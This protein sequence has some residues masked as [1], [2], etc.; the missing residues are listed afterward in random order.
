MILCSHCTSLNCLSMVWVSPLILTYYTSCNITTSHSHPH[1]D[2]INPVINFFPAISN[3]YYYFISW[4]A[5]GPPAQFSLFFFV[6]ILRLLMIEIKICHDAKV[7]V[8]PYTP[9][10]NSVTD[11]VAELY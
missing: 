8:T 2:F 7:S 6:F 9:R 5:T 3:F 10:T 11:S 1:L 4:P